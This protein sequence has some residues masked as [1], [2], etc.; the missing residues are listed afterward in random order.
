MQIRT[1]A[2]AEATEFRSLIDDA[3]R[4]PGART[5]AAE[6]FPVILGE[7]NRNWQF[8]AEEGGE[9]VGCL[10]CLVRRFR[11]NL[12]EV[13]VGGVGSVVTRN[14]RRGRG[15]SRLL[16]DH[17][18]AALRRQKVPLAVLW[19]DQPEIY[20]GRGFRPAGHELHLL[21]EEAD[22]D[23]LLPAHWRLRRYSRDD[24]P[25]IEAL[26][27]SH[28]LVTLREDGDAERL[29]GMPGTE[30]LVAVSGAGAVAAYVF[31]GKGADFGDYALEWGGPPEAVAALL[32]QA[33]AAGLASRA[34]APLGAQAL[35]NLL[36]ARGAVW[37]AQPSG[38]WALLDPAALVPLAVEAGVEPPPAD[39]RSEV[40]AWLGT[41]TDD[42]LPTE[43]PLALAV[44]GFD[45]V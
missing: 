6:D 5:S 24:L 45:S 15:I 4:P 33:R 3:I 13:A 43:G 42:G 28:S 40:T 36:V 22:L 31:C 30:G 9:L 32:G 44:W 10:A 38:Y 35:V 26:Y 17:A 18:L 25:A 34:L 20:T 11:A 23:G 14:D 7:G 2:A 29:Y 1:I 19:T 27:A 41:V 12:G 16:Q 39:Q 21:L 37:F 8:V